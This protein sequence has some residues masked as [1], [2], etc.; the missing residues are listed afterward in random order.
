M[1]DNA[2][3]AELLVS[4]VRM[5]A[6]DVH[7]VVNALPVFRLNG[8]LVPVDDPRLNTSVAAAFQRRLAPEDVQRL[9]DQVMNAQQRERFNSCGEVDLSYSIRGVARFRLN[10]FRQR[11]TPG[12]AVRPVKLDIPP[13]GR[14]G[15]PEVASRLARLPRGLILVCGPTGSGKS[16]TLASMIDLLNRE[17]RLHVIT[18]EDPIEYTYSHKNCLIV[19]REIGDDTLSFA[20][21]L[22]A[23][24][25]EDPDVIMVG[26]MRDLETIAGA[27]TAAETGHL[28]LATLHTN[29]AA[30]T[31][32]RIVD[33]FPPN[34]QQQIKV[35]LSL[36]LQ[37][38]LVQQLIPR[39]DGRDRVI[40]VE[41]MVATP[42][43]RNLIREGKTHQLYTLIQTGTR[44]GMQTMEMSLK[45]LVHQ[46][47]ISREE[48]LSRAG[49]PEG[50][51]R[52]L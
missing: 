22:R 6:S 26:E 25:R 48:A 10:I 3:L 8:E 49:D 35:Q 28:V 15:L 13:I 9:A 36:S 34:Q 38:V 5:F 30:Q 51:L 11:G 32:D 16:T 39:Q 23:A 12:I 50:L 1:S 31:I 40:A 27:I 21:A 20:S 4:A 45:N 43:A 44:F 33:V 46:G 19:Q 29:S 42:A 37:A 17:A 41:V 18:I 47:L 14:L 2:E 52:I 24:M 7:L